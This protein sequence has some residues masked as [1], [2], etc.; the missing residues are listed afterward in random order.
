MVVEFHQCFDDYDDWFLDQ[1][2]ENVRSSTIRLAKLASI[3]SGIG[4]KLSR[5]P[6]VNHDGIGCE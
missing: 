1:E 2:R 4:A 5:L 6:G 3:D